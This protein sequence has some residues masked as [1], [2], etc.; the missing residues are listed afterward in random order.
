MFVIPL[1]L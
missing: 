1:H